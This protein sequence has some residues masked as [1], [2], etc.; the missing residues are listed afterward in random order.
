MCVCVL[1]CMCEREREAPKNL[2][3]RNSKIP[4]FVCEKSALALHANETS[5]GR[6]QCI[7][8]DYSTI[9]AYEI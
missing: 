1:V 9:N 6:G 2:M 7:I 5:T 8:R 3:L 4:V